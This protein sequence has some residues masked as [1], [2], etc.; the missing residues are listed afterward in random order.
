MIKNLFITLVLFICCMNIINGQQMDN[1]KLD[2]IIYT[3]SDEVEGTNGSW[4]FLIDS[5]VFICL[6]DQ[7]NN[8]MRII[9]PIDK[10]ENVSKEIMMECME[11]NFHSA[12]DVKYAVSDE[13]VWSVFIHPLKQLEKS[14][15]IDAISQVYSASRTFGSTYSSGALSFPSSNKEEDVYRN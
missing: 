6:T 5:T 7:I 9:S 14:Q 8:R 3:L 4:Q 2:A 10:V 15:V 12:L 11:A 1:Q 13:I